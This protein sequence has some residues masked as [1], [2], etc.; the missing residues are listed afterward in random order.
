MTTYSLAAYELAVSL[1]R[2]SKTIMVEGPTDKRVLSRMMLEREAAA[3]R[4]FRCVIDDCAIV[5]D[6]ALAGKGAKTKVEFI[7]NAI[8]VGSGRFNWLVDRE[9]DDVDIERPQDFV[10][11]SNAE[12]GVRTKGHSIENYWM[13]LDALSTYLK[14]FFGDGLTVEFFT[15]LEARFSPM[16]RL[17]A[18]YSFTAKRMSVVTRCGD[19]IRSRD[20]KWTGAEYVV[21]PSLTSSLRNRGV[22]D[23][24]AAEINIELGRENLKAASIDVLQWM[25][26]GHLGEELIRACAAS[27]A[28]ECGVQQ[29]TLDQIERGR[30]SEKLLHDSDFLAR[31]DEDAIHPLGALLAWAQ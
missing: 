6:A 3:G 18:A 9:W 24:I 17:A 20:I 29:P 27:L 14:M 13:R 12:V 28:G 4:S 5:N 19:A 2:T 25:C 7:A 10:T 22:A 15:L 1:I 21:L 8:G 11:P 23:D 31:Q 30:R 26:H 16:L